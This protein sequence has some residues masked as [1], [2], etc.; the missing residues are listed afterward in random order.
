M[1]QAKSLNMMTGDTITGEGMP[2]HRNLFNKGQ[3]I[4]NFTVSFLTENI[5]KL[6]L[7]GRQIAYK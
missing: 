6:R 7:H 3:L 4:I 5:L 2:R 1:V